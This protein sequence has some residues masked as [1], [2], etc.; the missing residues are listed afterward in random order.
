MQEMADVLEW[1]PRFALTDLPVPAREE[2]V[3]QLHWLEQVAG[4]VD[5][6]RVRR[7]MKSRWKGPLASSRPDQA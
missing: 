4:A 3:Q 2:A 7:W 5:D 1:A 6:E